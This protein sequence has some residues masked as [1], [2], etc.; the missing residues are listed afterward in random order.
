MRTFTEAEKTAQ[1]EL[2][3]A[4]E[5][6]DIDEVLAILESTPKAVATMAEEGKTPYELALFLYETDLRA[7]QRERSDSHEEDLNASKRLLQIVREAALKD[8]IDHQDIKALERMESK[9][10]AFCIPFADGTMPRQ[11]A[12]THGKS[13]VLAWAAKDAENSVGSIMEG[14]SH[15]TTFFKG[16]GEIEVEKSR[17][18]EAELRLEVERVDALIETKKNCLEEIK[19][20]LVAAV[21]A[22]KI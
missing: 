11:Y 18:E 9:K 1:E 20:T 2:V 6:G 16:L 4:I 19:G 8:A 3:D 12:K 17:L 22:P 15:M 14:L 21:G 5:M 13:E 10:G 7:Y